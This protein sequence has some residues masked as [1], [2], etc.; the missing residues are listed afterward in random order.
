[1]MHYYK[2]N[3]ADWALHTAHLSLVEEAVYFRLINHY[4]DTE[5]PIPLATQSVIRRL[6]LG[7]DQDSVMLILSEFFIE[8]DKGFLHN[9][10]ESLLKEYRKTAKKNKANGAKGG[11][12]K[13][14]AAPSLTQTEPSGLDLGTHNEPKHNPNQEL[15]TKNQ[16]L[17]TINQIANVKPK[18]DQID[19]AF[20]QL[21]FDE[22]LRHNP[23][24][25]APNLNAW[26][27]DARKM[28]EID[29][30]D[31]T[32][33]G[34]VWT[35]V[36]NDS[37]WST[38]ILSISKFREKYDMVSMKARTGGNPNLSKAGNATLNNIRDWEPT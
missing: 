12:P 10:C 21:A 5:M 3:I 31:P 24:H 27:E 9:R 28:R 32:E 7:N 26:A 20:A 16:E 22:L 18:F 15:I 29:N 8:T 30:R 33:M 13:A 19:M 14:G 34:M 37:F 36:R 38:N 23:N 35:W 25:K 1:M 4:Y 11:R 6:R 17:K 2:F